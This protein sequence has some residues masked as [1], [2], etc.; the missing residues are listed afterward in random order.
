MQRSS[1]AIRGDASDREVHQQAKAH[2]EIALTAAITRLR[3]TAD[4]AKLVLEQPEPPLT[5]L[6]PM[7][8]M[9]FTANE[10]ELA[11]NGIVSEK[12]GEW[13]RI[14]KRLKNTEVLEDDAA[15]R[16]HVPCEMKPPYDVCGFL[17]KAKQAADS[18]D[19]AP[20]AAH[21]RETLTIVETALVEAA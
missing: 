4:I 12:E 9:L 3:L 13:H 15:L 16:D 7:R 5:D 17:A 18:L 10:K 1:E 21:H 6:K 8:D 19:G 20:S 2:R 11:T 14:S